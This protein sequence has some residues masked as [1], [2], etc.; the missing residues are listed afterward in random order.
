MPDTHTTSYAM[1][2]EEIAAMFLSAAHTYHRSGAQAR[3]RKRAMVMMHLT[4]ALAERNGFTDRDIIPL[5][6]VG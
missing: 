2:R 6:K 4:K 1:T 3:D 5:L